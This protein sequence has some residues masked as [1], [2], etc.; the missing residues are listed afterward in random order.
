MI[1]KDPVATAS[2]MQLFMDHQVSYT[3]LLM[4][5]HIKQVGLEFEMLTVLLP[6]KPLN[7]W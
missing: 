4:Y 2:A 6:D 5:V 7:D 1:R 3:V